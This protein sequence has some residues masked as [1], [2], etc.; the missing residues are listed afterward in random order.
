MLS[1]TILLP[2]C[3]HQTCSCDAS[4][5]SQLV[6]KLVLQHLV[7]LLGFKLVMHDRKA[8]HGIR[9]EEQTDKPCVHS[10]FCKVNVWV[11][12]VDDQMCNH[13]LFSKV[14]LCIT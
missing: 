2:A 10:Q 5:D 3:A 11:V 9:T 1:H 6:W 4:V 14:H 12:R 7:Q 13:P 8:T